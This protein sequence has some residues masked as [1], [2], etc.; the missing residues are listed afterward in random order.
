MVSERYSATTQISQTQI[1]ERMQRTQTGDQT[2][3]LVVEVLVAVDRPGEDAAARAGAE[4]LLTLARQG[5]PLTLIAQQFSQSP[6]ALNDGV[7]GWR[8][9]DLLDSEIRSAV[10]DLA[11][12]SFAG[13][14]RTAHGY[15][16]LQLMEKRNA[17]EL[18]AVPRFSLARMVLPLAGTAPETEVEDTRAL[19]ESI[20]QQVNGCSE[21]TAFARQIDPTINANPELGVGVIAQLPEDVR[22]LLE[23]A[24]IGVPTAAH[25][26]AQGFELFMICEQVAADAP[27]VTREQ[28]AEQL[29]IESLDEAAKTLLSTIRQNAVIEIRG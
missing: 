16:I 10:I 19:A 3:Y 2:Q 7:L 9:A 8:Y 28:V 14:I 6:S 12:G 4:Q 29:R 24:E 22:P 21:F 18:A 11:P 15:V 25:R 5:L 23:D 1:D 20:R 27:T 26:T 13:P 17:A